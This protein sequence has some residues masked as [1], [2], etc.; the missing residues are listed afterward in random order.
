MLVRIKAMDKSDVR[1]LA[2][3]SY[4]VY[5]PGTEGLANVMTKEIFCRP[6]LASQKLEPIAGYTYCSYIDLEVT[7]VPNYFLAGTDLS[8][9]SKIFSDSYFERVY[10][11]KDF[12]EKL[13]VSTIMEG[14]FVF[15]KS[16]WKLMPLN[17][18][19]SANKSTSSCFVGG[20][21][22][23]VLIDELVG[24]HE[25]EKSSPES[26]A[27][28]VEQEI[29]QDLISSIRP[30]LRAATIAHKKSVKRSW[31]KPDNIMI[32]KEKTDF[33]VIDCYYMMPVPGVEE[34]FLY[35]NNSFKREYCKALD[36]V[37]IKRIDLSRI[38]H[39]LSMRDKFSRKN[40]RN[41]VQDFVTVIPIEYRPTANK[42]PHHLVAAYS[43][44]ISTLS[45]YKGTYTSSSV[46]IEVRVNAY[47][48]LNTAVKNVM[49]VPDATFRNKLGDSYKPLAEML[50]GKKGQIRDRLQSSIVDYAGRAVIICDPDMP[51][52]HVGIPYKMLRETMDVCFI[53]DMKNKTTKDGEPISIYDKVSRLNRQF[54]SDGNFEKAGRNKMDDGVKKQIREFSRNAFIA[55]G[56]QP[57]LYRHGIQGFKVRPVEGSSIV[58]PPLVTPPYNADFDGDQ[59]WYSFPV[60]DAA[61]ADVREKM[62]VINNIFYS[63]D[64]TCN[65]IPRHEIIYGLYLASAAKPTGT[66]IKRFATR[67]AGDLDEIKEMIKSGAYKINDIVIIDNV[68]MSLGKAAVHACFTRS[69]FDVILGE[70]DFTKRATSQ[71]DYDNEALCEDKWC[72]DFLTFIYNN[73]LKNRDMF[74]KVCDN[75]TQMGIAVAKQYPPDISCMRVP[76][77]SSIK[78]AFYEEV[79]DIQ[80][81][82]MFGFETEESYSDKYDKMF[83][84]YQK[85]VE[86][87][88]YDSSNAGSISNDNGFKILADSRARGNKS[89]I[90][91]MFGIKGKMQKNSLEVF[92]CAIFNNM[93]RG[94]TGLEHNMTAFGGRQGQID[95]S[96]E[97]SKP[98]YLSRRIGHAV[99]NYRITVDDCGTTNGIMLNYRLLSMHLEHEGSSSVSVWNDTRDMFKEIV[100]GKTVILPDG[101]SHRVTKKN[102]DDIFMSF[103][104]DIEED[105]TVVQYEDGLKMR[106]PITC[107]NPCCS[108]CY[109]TDPATHMLPVARQHKRIGFEAAVTVGEPSTQMTMKNFQ[110]GGVAGD[111]NLTSAFDLINTYLGLT[112]LNT[113]RQ[114]TGVMVSDVIV[115]VEGPVKCQQVN[116]NVKRVYIMDKND[117]DTVVWPKSGEDI[118]MYYGVKTKDYVKVGD[119]LQ[120]ELGNLSINNV[121]EVLGLDFAIS[122]LLIKLYMIYRAEVRVKICH[123]ETIIASMQSYICKK[124]LKCEKYEYKSG[125]SYSDIELK[126]H[127]GVRSMD[128]FVKQL[129]G[130]D[131][132]PH[133]NHNA[134]R[135]VMFED[136][137]AAIASHIVRSPYD[138]MTDEYT[139]LSFGLVGGN[140]NDL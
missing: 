35:N 76:D 92:N 1:K 131:V 91:Q 66:V 5:T 80:N 23:R 109:G 56:R 6:E 26:C 62:F 100:V 59:M 36:E 89:T 88:I 42:R 90:M 64:G 40:F 79:R 24:T 94:L 101:A 65:I 12:N 112:D 39:L 114:K 97:T 17:D 7:W 84:K 106:S 67:T 82:F 87:Y 47:K 77:I 41:L 61:K 21:V 58:L 70:R 49:T 22:L 116:S 51:I 18:F 130:I 72:Q 83:K 98:G 135:G 46:N 123:F 2:H 55:L 138:Y 105:G 102:V 31:F 71:S 96:V 126:Q 113:S 8:L 119:N 108:V 3:K 52:T 43:N 75:F 81:D 78:N 85:Q 37:F 133:R 68:K 139:R 9:L 45:S 121:T 128:C 104:A 50:K 69:Y 132:I 95:K 115:P 29:M 129:L 118:T 99:S 10:N 16:S 120:A 137:S 86:E 73:D 63:K 93:V 57:T 4:P 44:V 28:R 27:N 136:Q 103:I 110:R 14:K 60:S 140:Y 111:A 74:P 117:P 33:H 15:D 34:E 13:S 125:C 53:D 19:K 122:Y 25:E 11:S 48:A 38:S 54:L 107:S 124:D 30:V 127:G 134:L 20:E 32:T